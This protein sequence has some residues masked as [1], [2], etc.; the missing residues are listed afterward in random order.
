[1]KRIGLFRE[2]DLWELKKRRWSWLRKE[3]RRRRF[4]FH[5]QRRLPFPPFFLPL[6]PSRWP[7]STT[8]LTPKK[9]QTTSNLP[10]S[11][12][13]LLSLQPKRSSNLP[14]SR[15]QLLL[16]LLLD[17]LLPLTLPPLDSIFLHPR[18]PLA[19]EQLPSL[20]SNL[21][22]PSLSTRTLLPALR[23]T[24]NLPPN[25]P[26]SSL[27]QEAALPLSSPCFQHPSSLCLKGKRCPSLSS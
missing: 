17:L 23:P 5:L 25:E 26:K 16:L 24:S 4:R 3:E 7:L 15:L 8:D 22:P 6:A 9:D 18:S 10:L 27:L 1:M 20:L 19:N 13:L 11:L 14:S 12:L 2:S 21:R